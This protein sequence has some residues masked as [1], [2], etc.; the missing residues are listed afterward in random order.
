V[1]LLLDLLPVVVFFGL[2]RVAKWFP[3]PTVQAVSAI[4]GEP[5]GTPGQ[6]AE[7]AAVMLSTVGAMVAT[8]VQIAWLRLRQLPIRPSVWISAVLIVVFGGLTLWLHNE[9]FIKWKPSILY[10]CFAS[11]LLGGRWLAGRNLLGSLLS[12][13]LQLPPSAWDTLMYL[14][15]GFFAALGALNLYVAYH[16]STDAWV[17]FKTFGMMGLTLIFSVATGWF[18]MRHLPPESEGNANRHPASP[19]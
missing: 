7:M 4:F 10:W 11:V 5:T 13:E 19:H 16:W 1:K 18:I 12:Q 8:A 14:W 2:F 9:W 15:A 3:D 17:N 6:Q